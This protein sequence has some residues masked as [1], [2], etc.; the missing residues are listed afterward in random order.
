MI[1]ERELERRLQKLEESTE[2]EPPTAWM[3]EW[4]V[5][6]ELWDD[7]ERAWRY[8]LE[9]GESQTDSDADRKE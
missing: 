1:T 8:A 7:R 4:D 2:S 6:R 9:V 3:E 5:P